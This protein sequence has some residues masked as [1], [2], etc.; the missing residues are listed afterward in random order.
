MFL[1]RITSIK[2]MFVLNHLLKNLFKMLLE[3]LVAI[4][5]HHFTKVNNG[6]IITWRKRL[7]LSVTAVVPEFLEYFIAL[8]CSG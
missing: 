6:S 4:I 2:D 7:T 3:I 8:A 1:Y 5:Q